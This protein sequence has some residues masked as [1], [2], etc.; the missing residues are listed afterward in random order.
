MLDS[1]T[2]QLDLNHLRLDSNHLGWDGMAYGYTSDSYASVSLLAT[3]L[4][5]THI[6]TH[7]HTHSLYRILSV[8]LFQTRTSK[9]S[10]PSNF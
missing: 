9:S 6:H 10:Y 5:L 8:Q 1:I 7:T 4:P 2:L 3:V